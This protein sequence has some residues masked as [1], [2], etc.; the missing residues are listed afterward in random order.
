MKMKKILLSLM[1]ITVATASVVAGT[2]AFFT[3]TEVSQGNVMVAG[4]IDLK[5]DH[6]RQT[7]NGV[8]CKTCGLVIKSDTTNTITARWTGSS[9]ENL[10]T[11]QAAKIVS[12]HATD[13]ADETSIRAEWIW[14]EADKPSGDDRSGYE[15]TNT[16]TWQGPISQAK[17]E[18]A[19]SG[20]DNYEVFVNGTQVVTSGETQPWQ[21]IKG[22]NITSNIKQGQNT[23]TFRVKNTG[24]HYAGLLYRVVVG[25]NCGDPYFADFQAKCELWALKDLEGE[26]FFNFNDIKPGDWGT[27]LISYHVYDN[28]ANVCLF[29]ENVT[30]TSTKN[31]GNA[32][33]LR[34]WNANQDGTFQGETPVY[35]YDG[36]FGEFVKSLGKLSALTTKYIGVEW[37][38][39]EFSATGCDGSSMG[40]DYQGADLSAD[41]GFY[42]IQYRHN[43]NFD[44]NSLKTPVAA[45]STN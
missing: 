15:F 14:S 29:T 13:W 40:N 32:I 21:T 5:V 7:Y 11:P 25:G 3:D 34:V 20:D 12:K 31:L 37:C 10:S 27:N 44:C 38:A 33:E 9:W 16:F 23:I 39:G 42:A 2:S 8:D 24:G 6:T 19:I 18:L 36:T 28:D 26:K 22:Y 43:E 1:V 4:S 30:S 41:L 17:L 35:V 45:T